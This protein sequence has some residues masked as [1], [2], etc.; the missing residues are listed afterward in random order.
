MP[1]DWPFS[2]TNRQTLRI[3]LLSLSLTERHRPS[4][5]VLPVLGQSKPTATST[6]RVMDGGWTGKNI[7]PL[8]SSCVANHSEYLWCGFYYLPSYQ[9]KSLYQHTNPLNTINMTSNHQG[10]YLPTNLL[11]GP[12]SIQDRLPG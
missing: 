10:C 2:P 8:G 3:T 4:I 9:P 11:T 12:I 5:Q 6:P 7:F 1:R